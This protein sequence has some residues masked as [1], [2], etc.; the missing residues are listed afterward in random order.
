MQLAPTG[1]EARSYALFLLFRWGSLTKHGLP[2]V[3]P[4]AEK[5]HQQPD[6]ALAAWHSGALLAWGSLPAM[7]EPWVGQG[8]LTDI[9]LSGA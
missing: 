5:R 2:E 1:N 9:S 4:G 3:R 8:H 6:R 7:P